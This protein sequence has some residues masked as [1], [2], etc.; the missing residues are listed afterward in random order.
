[1]GADNGLSFRSNVDMDVRTTGD[2]APLTLTTKGSDSNIQVTATDPTSDV[3][4]QINMAMT[5]TAQNE[6]NLDSTRSTQITA[7]V[8]QFGSKATS[9]VQLTSGDECNFFA[10]G[11][12]YLEGA[13]GVNLNAIGGSDIDIEADGFLFVQVWQDGSFSTL[14]ESMFF[15]A[16]YNITYSTESGQGGT[17]TLAST[18]DIQINAESKTAENTILT[19]V[20]D[21]YSITA[22]RWFQYS[23]INAGKAG[24]DVT[25]TT[26]GVDSNI[27][28]T[29][30]QGPVEIVTKDA[31]GIFIEGGDVYIDSDGPATLQV[32][33]SIVIQTEGDHS[34]IELTAA[35][36]LSVTGGDMTFT[37]SNSLKPTI[38]NGLSYQDYVAYATGG[39]TAYS[40][41][42]AVQTDLS[43]TLADAGFNMWAN[44]GLSISADNMNFIG[45]TRGEFTNIGVGLSAGDHGTMNLNAP[46]SFTVSSAGDL[47]TRA[48]D[49][50]ILPFGDLTFSSSGVSHA[51]QDLLNVRAGV[52]I[53]SNHER[54]DI[55]IF[56]TDFLTANL[57][58]RASSGLDL[59]ADE[60]MTLLLLDDDDAAA[61]GTYQWQSDGPISFAA[62]NDLTIHETS[63]GDIT[64]LGN[65]IHYFTAGA[66]F[67]LTVRQRLEIDATANIEM[68]SLGNIVYNGDTTNIDL[69]GAEIYGMNSVTFDSL[70]SI[71]LNADNTITLSAGDDDDPDGDPNNSFIIEATDDP[72]VF[73]GGNVNINP[74]HA[75]DFRDGLAIPTVNNVNIITNFACGGAVPR[76]FVYNLATNSF[77]F[78]DGSS[79]MCVETYPFVRA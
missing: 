72:M 2:N 3:L 16:D 15:S 43:V 14:Q 45:N 22:T 9:N 34:S 17:L 75:V 77:C 13:N 53:Q 33:E 51:P 57:E 60:D 40:I 11:S 68:Y 6:F 23:L 50:V 79:Y 58:F 71:E 52:L 59:Y 25:L 35:G 4:F 64:F 21:D 46:T 18:D 26:T 29:A 27:V 5:M 12:L 8:D 24:N 62:E 49:I 61:V 63:T 32:A 73:T 10:K 56:T 39:A 65:G 31:G 30:Q 41:R 69:G 76:S 37:T 67:S 44:T 19:R 66:D 55:R 42:L 48:K 78:C 74:G 70:N 20:A 1:M 36:L 47:V 28:V 38:A 54:A 7:P